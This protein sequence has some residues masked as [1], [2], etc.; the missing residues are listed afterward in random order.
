MNVTARQLVTRK[1]P[2]RL[3]AY[4]PVTTFG[5]KYPL[6]RLIRPYLNRLASGLM[7]SYYYAKQI[8]EP[9]RIPLLVDSGGFASL[10]PGSSVVPEGD[11]GNLAVTR[12]GHTE[13]IHPRDVLEL[14]EQ[15]AEVAFSLDFPIPPGMGQKEA[16]DR[17][18]RTIAN[19]HWALANRRRRDLL[20]FACVQAW[21]A[22]S[23]R[24]CA[25]AYAGSGF[26]GIALGGLVPRARD[27][28]QVLAMARAVREEIGDLPLHVFGLGKP[29]LIE[30][31]MGAGVDSVDSSS[32]VKLAA[33]GRS[34]TASDL[35]LAD[36]SPTER[37]HLAIANLAFASGKTLPLPAWTTLLAACGSAGHPFQ[38]AE[39]SDDSRQ[40]VE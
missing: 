23:A 4:F 32:H 12:D 33:E 6:D 38:R 17:Q 29:E 13:R 27:A 16:R 14:Q 19:A 18:K 1:G 35:V 30:R 24:K 34:W 3:P 37:L 8:D 10:L 7:V 22:A 28:E 25:R 20:L 40:A 9:L 39:T 31:L 26:D 36:A 21:D 15:A 5:E 11:G 2:I